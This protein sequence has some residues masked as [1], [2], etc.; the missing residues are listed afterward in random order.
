LSYTGRQLKAEMDE[1]LETSELLEQIREKVAHATDSYCTRSGSRPG[2]DITV[3]AAFIL[4]QLLDG[5]NMVDSLESTDRSLVLSPQT[6]KENEHL[7]FWSSVSES[8]A[9]GQS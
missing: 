3:F 2:Q 4:Q 7:V 9:N 5:F 6:S 8:A 1:A